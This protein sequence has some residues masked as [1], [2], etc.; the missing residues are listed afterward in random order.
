M[1]I[2]EAIIGEIEP[3]SLSDNAVEKAFIDACGH[4]GVGCVKVDYEYRSN[5]RQV[6]ALA[7]MYCLGRLRVLTNEQIGSISNSYNV[8]E[9]DKAIRSIAQGA[10]LSPDLVLADGSDSTVTYCRYW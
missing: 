4:F 9:I 6:C 2:L 5:W 8:K 7:A 3:Y 10:G 1:T